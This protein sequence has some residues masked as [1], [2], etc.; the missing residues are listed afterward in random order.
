MT[1][2]RPVA[3]SPS[4]RSWA[5]LVVVYLVWGSTYLAIR[6]AVEQLPPLLMAGTRYLIA[7]VILFPLAIRTGDRASRA[8]DRP[9]RRQWGAAAIVG[10]L[11]LAVGN[12]GV[13]LGERSV[14]SGLAAVLVAGVPL[15]M[16]VFAWLWLHERLTPL[17]V[18]G[19]ALGLAGVIVLSHPGG[20]TRLSGTLTVITA[21]VGWALGSVWSGRVPLVRRALLATAME[22]LTG[23]AALVLAGLLTGEGAGLHPAAVPLRCWLALAYLVGPGSLLALTCYGYALKTLPTAVVSTYAYVNPA[24]ALGLGALVLGERLTGVEGLGALLVLTAV[25]LTTAA[26]SRRF[27][28]P[29]LA[30][31]PGE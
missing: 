18:T 29:A 23:G 4:P 27:A 22:M 20:G 12:G 28:R 17:A 8:S 11:L 31:S 14:A 2:D 25:V 26:R 10:V 9:G 24:V 6:V 5:A 16:A 30:V 13:S 7:G 19:L 21:S 3:A 15:W 1:A